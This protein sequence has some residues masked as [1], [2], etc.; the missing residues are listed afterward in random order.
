[1]LALGL[2]A[3]APA[4]MAASDGH[5]GDGGHGKHATSAKKGPTTRKVKLP[6]CPVLGE[7]VDFSVST[8]TKEGPVYFCCKMCIKK[9]GKKPEKYAKKTAEQRKTLAKLP[10]VQV[11]CPVSGEPIDGKSFIEKNGKRVDF[12][13]ADCK[14]KY[15]KNPGKYAA[16]L[17]ASYTYQTLCPVMGGKINPKV[18]GDLPTG[19]R[20]Y[21]CCPGCDKMMSSQPEKYVATLAKQGIKIDVKKLKALQKKGKHK[22]G[23]AGGE[24]K[25]GGHG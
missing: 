24:H 11:G 2:W 3:A 7:T 6:E 16:K 5:G 14:D 13:C 12:C 1:M 4:A 25:H 8:M 9:Y 17:E 22:K 18:F 23:P 19:Q 20:I 10:R 15:S 21:Y